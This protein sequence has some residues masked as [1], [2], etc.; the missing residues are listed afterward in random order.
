MSTT[1]FPFSNSNTLKHSDW[2][3]SKEKNC[4]QTPW[5]FLRRSELSR[6]SRSEFEDIGT[7]LRTFPRRNKNM[8]P[9]KKQHDFTIGSWQEGFWK[10]YF[11][12][13]ARWSARTRKCCG[14]SQ[15]KLELEQFYLESS[16]ES[17]RTLEPKTFGLKKGKINRLLQAVFRFLSFFF[18]TSKRTSKQKVKTG[19][20]PP[21]TAG[22]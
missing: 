5:C 17:T 13:H 8:F 11:L 3:H 19:G 16:K 4:T 10:V 12:L 1:R 9:S 6:M 7:V 14:R 22:G 2:R 15:F 21:I 20:S 18:W